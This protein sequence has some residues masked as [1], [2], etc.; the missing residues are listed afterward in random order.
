M[1]LDI[2]KIF[3]APQE[4]IEPEE[5]KRLQKLEILSGNIDALYASGQNSEDCFIKKCKYNEQIFF[6]FKGFYLDQKS[7][8]NNHINLEKYLKSDEF[9]IVLYKCDIMD[10]SIS[11]EHLN[12]IKRKVIIAN[13]NLPNISSC[14]FENEVFLRNISNNST[15]GGCEFA[16]EVYVDGY[17]YFHACTFNS[18]FIS[19]N[20]RQDISFASSIF[21]KSFKLDT[22]NELGE[23]KF[24]AAHFKQKFTMDIGKFSVLDFS[25]AEFDCELNLHA[26]QFDGININF[27]NAIFNQKLSFNKSIIN[28]EIL[29]KEACFESDL[30]F[31]EAKFDYVVNLDKSKFKGEAQFCGTQFSEAILTETTFENK[32]DFS[33]AAF[34]FNNK[35][36]FTNAIFKADVDFSSATFDDEARF[37]N[38]DFKGTAIFENTKFKK[39]ADFKTDIN[40]TF[41]KD[42]NFSNATFHDNAYF[43][44]RVFED[45]ADFH[46][47]DF[48]KVA[49]FYSV[50]F[51]KPV[52]FSSI[53]FNGALNFVNAKTDF[54]YE[55][56][57]EL[58]E[59]QIKCDKSIDNIKRTNDFRD[60]FRLMKYN[61]NNK[62]NALDASLFHRLEL[63][64]KEL[65]LEFTLDKD[66][67]NSKGTK[68]ADEIEAKPKSK[69]RIEILL[70]LITL[71]LYRNISDHHTN[72]LRI[73]NFMVLTIAVY[74]FYLYVYKNCILTWLVDYSYEWVCSILL[75][76]LLWALFTT[77]RE[78]SKYS[79]SWKKVLIWF[80]E[81]VLISALV[82]YL[83]SI[84]YIAYIA[85]FITSYLLIYR[86]I[87][88]AASKYSPS[89]LIYYSLFIVILFAKPF[90]IAP[91]IGIFTSEQAI[92]SKFKEYTIRYNENGLDDML[93]DANLTNTKKDNKLDFIV[94]NRKTILDELDD[95][96]ALLNDF[97]EKLFNNPENFVDHNMSNK[98]VQKKEAPQKSYAEALAALK[99]DEI[100]QST[101]KS[102]NLLYGLIMLLVIYSLTKTARKNSVVPS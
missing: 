42:A 74:G 16:K 2:D 94:E 92:E 44:N 10:N 87:V 102:A 90:L 68:S 30:I 60:G 75:L 77:C 69:N 31:A 24:E 40:L 29:F 101:Q 85:L 41:G 22:K 96:K 78:T 5:L 84:N 86:R 80:I 32:A 72:L 21:N 99:Y 58:I 63:Y 12:K 59:T 53:I 61:L 50:T 3:D 64:C 27:T 71:K 4:K 13:S 100:M 56:L 70:D 73:I 47:A 45:F 33:N 8:R 46:E 51:K 35:A 37:L 82:V 76:V 19:E 28:C 6:I 93:L 34:K 1:G 38:A 81:L 65:E 9:N 25:S 36:D 91:F 15:F 20:S 79:I 89:Y 62:G 48:K 52:N 66:G 88:I 97:V 95:D 55:E 14:E 57:K 43:N 26:R 39:E 17:A 49:C 23:V 18:D 54:T 98:N 67:E 11:I 7:D 83:V